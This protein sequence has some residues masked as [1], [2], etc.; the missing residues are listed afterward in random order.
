MATNADEVRQVAAREYGR[1]SDAR[2]LME[3]WRSS[4][5]TLVRFARRHASSS[6]ESPSGRVGWTVE[7]GDGCSCTRS[8][9]WTTGWRPV[10]RS[11]S[12]S[13]G[14]AR[15]RPPGFGSED[16]S[17]RS[18]R[19]GGVGAVLTLPASVRIY[20]A[21]EALDLRRSFDG[22][23]AAPHSLI[24]HDPLNGHRLVFPNR[25]KNWIKL[26]VWD[27]TG[28][29]LNKRLERG[30][31]RLAT[32]PAPAERHVEVDPGELGL[33]MEGLDLRG[34]AQRERWRRLPHETAAAAAGSRS[35]PVR[36]IF[37]CLPCL[38]P[39]KNPLELGFLRGHDDISCGL[40][41]A[42]A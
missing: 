20:V 24:R 31:S 41:R 27:R 12:R 3:A 29:L 23:A 30:A 4:G 38:R 8:G 18:G 2:L 21:A 15:P 1:E 25:R 11:R 9:S 17:S 36:A 5:E 40:R 13:R 7:A 14:P 35:G 39:L 28:Y 19:A 16:L 22:L 37:F 34:A 26:L 33:M 42:S 32:E 10:H 6:S